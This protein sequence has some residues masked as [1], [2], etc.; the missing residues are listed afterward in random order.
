ML[1]YLD[2]HTDRYTYACFELHK[3]I[4]TYTYIAHTDRYIHTYIQIQ[5]HI[6]IDITPKYIR[7]FELHTDMLQIQID[8]YT[9][10][11]ILSNLPHTPNIILHQHNT[12]TYIVV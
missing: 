11:D 12:L 5:T 6:Q 7:C 9:Y 4:Y 3:H 1:I 8:I 10:I 2:T